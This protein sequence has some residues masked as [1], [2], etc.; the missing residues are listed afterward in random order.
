MNF[1]L[2]ILYHILAVFSRWQSFSANG[3]KS[4]KNIEKPSQ[5]CYNRTTIP[6]T[7]KEVLFY[8]IK[9][10][11]EKKLQ[12]ITEFI[13]QYARENNGDAPDLQISWIT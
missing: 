6:E 1:L 3:I 9:V 11:D 5:K 2:I 10:M 7:K 4:S 12:E 13:K 8:I